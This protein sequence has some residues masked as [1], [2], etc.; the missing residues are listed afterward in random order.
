[1]S[2]YE[3]LGISKNATEDEIKQSYRNLA[4]KHHPDK[5]GNKEQFQ[6]IQE[7]YDTLSDP[8]KKQ[9]YDNPQPN[10]FEG[11]GFPFGGGGFPFGD[12][13]PFGGFQQHQNKKSDD[14]FHTCNIT[15]QDV[16]TGVKKSFNLKHDIICSS[17]KSVCNFC[18]GKGVVQQRIQIG[19]IVQ[20]LNQQC[21]ACNSTGNIRTKSDCSICES[22]GFIT[23]KQLVEINIP[24]GV[25]EGKRYVFKKN[26]KNSSGNFVITIHINE[27]NLFKRRNNHLVYE[28]PLTLKESIIG[29][30]L[31]F[32]YFGEKININTKNFGIINPSNE[33]II[34]N[35]GLE[36]TNGVKGNLIFKFTIIYPSEKLILNN[37]Q[38]SII[39][40]AFK[41]IL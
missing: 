15:L 32:D 3:T 18:N 21:S 25:E 33:Y 34:Y 13:F 29:K 2:H 31:F 8:Q 4:K 37:E 11:G 39:E 16:Y 36:N 30:E 20:I 1:M 22:K 40:N 10:F 41:N 28:L 23:E 7:A 26:N 17:C 5:G 35:K 14:V 9:E 27:H 12:G 6:K 19:P 38:I 24:K